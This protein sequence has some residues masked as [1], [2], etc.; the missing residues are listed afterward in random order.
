M[1]EIHL[2]KPNADIYEFILSDNR[3]NPQECFF[4]D[5]TKENTDTANKLG[6]NV[7]NIDETK[8]DVINLFEINKHI[9]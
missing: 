5:D 8:E 7:W 1:E 3:L 9:F 4:V 6:I 2:R